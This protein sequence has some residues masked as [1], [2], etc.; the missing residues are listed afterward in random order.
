MSNNTAA[1][2]SLTYNAGRNRWASCCRPFRGMPNR[3]FL[4]KAELM[5]EHGVRVRSSRV[6]EF[7]RIDEDF[8]QR[9][10]MLLV[11]FRARNIFDQPQPSVEQFRPYS[12]P[13]LR[14]DCTRIGANARELRLTVR[15]CDS[16]VS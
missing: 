1:A 11:V 7:K 5:I 10:E 3:L 15:A 8:F 16:G 13:Y 6:L 2:S 9:N 12:S 14:K 4:R